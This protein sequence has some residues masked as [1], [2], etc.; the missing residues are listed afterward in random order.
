[1]V[2][3]IVLVVQRR[4]FTDIG[5]GIRLRPDI[6]PLPYCVF[7]VLGGVHLLGLLD[8]R[9]EL[10]ARFGLGLT[11]HIAA[12]W[13]AYIGGRPCRVTPLPAAIAALAQAPLAVSSAFCR[14]I[15]SFVIQ[16]YTRTEIVKG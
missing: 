13:L 14:C 6:C 1:M 16:R 11:Q 15:I 7:F 12:D 10:F 4:G 9:L 5:L 2:F 3:N 8:H